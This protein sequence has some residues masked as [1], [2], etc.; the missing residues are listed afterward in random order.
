M[1]YING[2]KILVGD[3]VRFAE[4]AY[5]VVVCSIDDDKYTEEYPKNEWSYLQKGI[6][7]S[8]PQAGLIHFPNEDESVV[9][10]ERK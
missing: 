9:L 10:I 6:L 2:K 3:K 8:S 7:I 1:N 4:E 5:G